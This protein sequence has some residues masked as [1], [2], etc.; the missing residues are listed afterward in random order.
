M[1]TKMLQKSIWNYLQLTK[2]A[3]EK[4]SQEENYSKNNNNYKKN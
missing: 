2:V 3:E 4:R 1:S